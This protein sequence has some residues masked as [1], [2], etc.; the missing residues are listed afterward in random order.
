[1]E[2]FRLELSELSKELQIKITQIDGRLT[3]M[4]DYM[5]AH[6]AYHDKLMEVQSARNWQLWV[7]IIGAVVGGLAGWIFAL[8][9]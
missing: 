1:M 9:K 4:E 5:K 2:D 3:F 7:L 8:M 6:K